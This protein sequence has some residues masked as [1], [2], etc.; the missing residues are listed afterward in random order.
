MSA[1]YVLVLEGFGKIFN[2]LGVARS[3]G[4]RRG[5]ICLNEKWGLGV[6]SHLDV[7]EII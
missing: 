4:E 2:F 3:R 7:L 6:F 1:W 5:K